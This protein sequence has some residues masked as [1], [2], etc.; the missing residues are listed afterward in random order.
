MDTDSIPLKDRD[1]C[2]LSST[3][4]L[5]RDYLIANE[6]ENHKHSEINILGPPKF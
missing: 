3:A 6:A 5:I 4:A 2:T 1:T